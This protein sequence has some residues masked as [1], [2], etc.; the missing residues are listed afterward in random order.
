MNAW[1]ASA[2]IMLAGLGACSSKDEAAQSAAP[3]TMAAVPAEG[4]SASPNQGRILQL[5]QAAGYT[6]AEVR[7]PAGQ[8]V[9]MAGGPLQLQVG[10]T[11]QWGDYA[12]MQNFSSKTLGR[13]FAQILFVNNWGAPGGVGSQV[14][15]HGTLPAHG[16]HAGVDPAPAGALAGQGLVKHVALAG[17]YT[18]LEV[19]QPEADLWLAAPQAAVKVG[20]KVAWTGGALMQNFA[21]KSLGRTFD[22]IIFV[23]NFTVIQ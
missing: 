23:G 3:G 8:T 19:A 10:D 15:A 16:V 9:W 5:Q 18:Y 7:T 20:E 12:V 17:G 14:A 21:A 13:T 11:V 1:I 4:G 6:Y 22:K 2:L